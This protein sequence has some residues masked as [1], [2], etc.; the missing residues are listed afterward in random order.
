[1]ISENATIWYTVCPV[2]SA[3]HIAVEYGWLER[4]F[5]K[6]GIAI[7]HISNLPKEESMAHFT[8][9]HPRLFRDGGCIPPIWA[10]S[11]GAMNKVIGMVWP[12]VG[13]AILVRR[14]S[15]IKT[16]KDLKGK[17]L[18]LPD[19][20]Y[21]L[22]DF[23][24]ASIERGFIMALK[25]HGL[26][27]DDVQFV[28]LPLTNADM[29]IPERA[30]LTKNPGP[31]ARPAKKGQLPQQSEVDALQQ[32]DVD[33]ILSSLGRAHVLEQAG[34]AKAIYDLRDH[35]DWRFRIHNVYP[36]TIT[37]STAFAEAH[38]DLVVRWMKV[39]VRAGNWAKDNAA[40]I[41]RVVSGATGVPEKAL[42]A[43]SEAGF[44]QHLVPEI[45]DVGLEGLALEKQFLL[46]H[47]FIENDFDVE[48]WVDRSFLDAAME[49][50]KD[51]SNE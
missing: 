23:R 1:M 10:R 7:S 47:G 6:T 5:E 38:P 48:R 40:E 17:R 30:Q 25:A 29:V 46:E 32:G 33:A 28:D 18:S 31:E 49:E 26:E 44:H 16:V 13:Q 35:P 45:T 19:R 50:I 24:R 12:N 11:R 37:V 2:P 3:S 8:H 9:D 15:S 22:I 39:L 21:G 41:L 51:Q 43:T 42:E 14:E 34:A 4:E 27:D 36:V 20:S